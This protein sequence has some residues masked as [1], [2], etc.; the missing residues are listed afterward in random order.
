MSLCQTAGDAPRRAIIW[1]LLGASLLLAA[2]AHAQGDG[3]RAYQ[4][5]PADSKSVS[6]YGLFV[7][8]NQALDPAR[9]TKGADIHGDEMVIQPTVPLVLAHRLGQVF[10]AVPL[11]KVSGSLPLATGSV[12]SSSSG[13]GDIQLGMEHNVVGPPAATGPAFDALRPGMVVNLLGKITMP[14]GAYSSSQ[15]LNMGSNRWSFQLGAP[16]CYYL[17][18]SFA[19][20][21][22]TTFELEPTVS[23][24]SAI[25]NPTGKD[26]EAPMLGL[27]EH[28]THNL[29]QALWASLDGLYFRGGETTTN[30]IRD[31]NNKIT[32]E[33]GGTV[34]C[35]VGDNLSF[36][37]T[38]GGAV[39]RNDTGM[40]GHGVRVMGVRSF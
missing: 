23:F 30:G 35:S 12:T 32:L 10:V 5:V 11:G 3:A 26:T 16:L 29:N 36:T 8:G 20:P 2:R 19:D 15:P 33:L 24:Y 17:G 4:F 22:L 18:D 28:V 40:E 9:I 31:G 27:E 14:T 39:G 37:L 38:Y 1:L 34:G 6:V 13:L 7:R 21:R 25:Q